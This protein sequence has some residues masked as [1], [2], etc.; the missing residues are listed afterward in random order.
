MR[1]KTIL[2]FLLALTLA[3]T[4]WAQTKISGTLQ[5]GKSDPS[6]AIP[7]GDRPGHAFAIGKTKCIWTTAP[8]VAGTQAKDHE[9]TLFVEVSGARGRYRS[10]AVGT[11]ASGDKYYASTQGTTTVKEGVTQ[12][13]EGAWSYTGGTGKLKG[14]KGKGTYKG[15]AGADGTMTIEMEGEYQ[16]PK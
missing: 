14:I 15:K 11:M 6:Y 13:T 2:L 3:V 8:E 10:A 5:C 4:A 1:F 16:L 12:T 7:V 9:Y